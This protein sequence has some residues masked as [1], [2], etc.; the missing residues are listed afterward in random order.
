M[1][2]NNLLNLVKNKK[3]TTM[4]K[5]ETSAFTYH[6][7]LTGLKHSYLSALCLAA[8]LTALPSSSLAQAASL[9]QSQACE[10]LQQ[11][12]NLTITEATVRKN[13]QSSSP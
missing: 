8:S 13:D 7:L 11:V 5:I 9:G 3:G 2:E 4:T 10:A 1:P 6:S 12:R